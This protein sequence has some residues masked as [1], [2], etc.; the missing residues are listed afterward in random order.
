MQ[1]PYVGWKN[2]G[3]TDDRNAPGGSWRVYWQSKTDEKWPDTCCV[4]GCVRR[5]TEGAHMY[6]PA[7]DRSEYIIPSCHYHNMQ[8]NAVYNLKHTLRSLVSANTN[9]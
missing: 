8:Y 3:G 1:Y 7:V 5:A 2:Q 6:C 9:K 4:L